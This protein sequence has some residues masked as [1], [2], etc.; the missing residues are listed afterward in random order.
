MRVLMITSEW[1]TPERPEAVPFIVRQAEFLQRAGIDLDVFHFRGGQNPRNY[2]KAWRQVREKINLM[3]YDL[4]HAQ[5]GQSGLLALPKRI[6]LVVTFRGDDVHGI[7]SDDDAHYTFKGRVLQ[8]VSR[9]VA[10]Q[11]SACIVVSP[12]LVELLPRRTYHVIPSGL[13]M[14]LFKPVDKQDAR[15]QLNL[16]PEKPLVLFGGNPAV[17]RKR[18]DLAQQV[19]EMVRDEWPEIEL[20]VLRNVPHEQIP[21]Y[22]NACDAMLMVSKHE[23]SPNVVKEALACNLPVV[24]VDVGDVR[25]RISGVKGCVLCA[26]DQ[27]ET[28]AQGLRDVLRSGERCEG[29]QA[30]QELDE[31]VIT[32]KVIRVYEEALRA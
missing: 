29:R 9:L 32:Q 15:R 16:D 8:Q 6:P 10:W 31:T 5:W 4:A 25:E 19:T 18:Y 1:P 26:D 17:L 24:S 14:D 7:I 28:I 22:M 23:G 21:L 2:L 13:D 20:L 12:H 3:E 11:A 30:V 27:P